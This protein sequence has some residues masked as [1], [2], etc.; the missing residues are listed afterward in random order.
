MIQG[1]LFAP[2]VPPF[3]AELAARLKRLAA[4]GIYF[5]T[6]SWKYEGWIGQIYSE[7]RYAYRGRFAKKRFEEECLAEYAETFPIVCGDFSFY[8]FPSQQYWRKLFGSAPP[9]LKFAFKVPEE[10]TAAQ[11]PSHERYGSRA[12]LLNPSFLD[13]GV[14]RNL[15]ADPLSP[16][17][18]RIAALIFEFGTFS[19]AIFENVDQFVSVLDP[20]LGLL[21]EGFRYAVEIRNA[22]F[23]RPE[24]LTCL[25]SHGVAHTYN[26][27][28]RM[29]EL[30]A[31]L[32][33]PATHTAAFTVTRALLKHGRSYEDAVRK[34]QPYREVQEPNE[35]ARTGLKEIVKQAR[36]AKQPA[37]IFVNNRLE[38][39]APQTIAAVTEDG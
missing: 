38:G 25:H 13:P 34:F 7:E 20:F 1:S 31:Q 35:P 11:F 26:S 9:S 32:R 28:T 10:I 2:E 12:G 4:E 30:P 22:E 21:P 36:A 27:W 37:F 5:G 8:Q 6:S 14:F 39:N 17:R 18:D 15:F 19:H 16:Y 33:F 3:R 24:Y 29:P 23:L